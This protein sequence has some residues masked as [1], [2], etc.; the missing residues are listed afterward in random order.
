MISKLNI[1]FYRQNDPGSEVI[2]ANDDFINKFADTNASNDKLNKFNIECQGILDK[3]A[4]VLKTYDTYNAHRKTAGSAGLS[5]YKSALIDQVV[6]LYNKQ[7]AIEKGQKT[8]KPPESD[9]SKISNLAKKQDAKFANDDTITSNPTDDL[10]SVIKQTDTPENQAVTAKSNVP[11]KSA[12]EKEIGLVL[13]NLQS[14]RHDVAE[15]VHEGT[16]LAK[17]EGS[18]IIIY[19]LG[20]VALLVTFWALFLR[21]PAPRITTPIMTTPIM[22]R[23][24]MTTPI[25]TTPIMTT[26]VMKYQ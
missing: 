26:P 8:S 22:T 10:K 17:K 11:K 13:D 7:L 15:I 23:P 18:N 16:V 14:K 1:N 9:I 5:T 2:K 21:A 3:F 4:I 25:M 12:I 6:A 20:G 24:I 19:I